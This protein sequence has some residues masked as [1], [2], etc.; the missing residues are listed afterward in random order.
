MRARLLPLSFVFAAA[1][2]AQETVP[3][4]SAMRFVP[5]D[6]I[7]VVRCAGPGAWK[8]QFAGTRLA[9]LL[10][11]PTLG[12][13]LAQ[14]G[15]ELDK[16]IAKARES[17]KVDAEA[18]ERFLGEYS[19]E[20]VVGVSCELGGLAEAIEKDE[21]PPFGVVVAFGPDGK[22]DLKTLARNA[23]EAAEDEPRLR[24]LK[25]G[26]R[27]LRVSH[28][29]DMMMTLPFELDGWQV[30]L[31][32]SEVEKQATALFAGKER[33]EMPA[34]HLQGPLAVHVTADKALDALLSA[35]AAKA[36]ENG[37]PMD[38]KAMLDQFGVASVR[39][40]D[41]VVGSDGEHA[42]AEARLSFNDKERG[43]L[44][45]L[46]PA[47]KA[48]PPTL[49]Y[50]PV[51]ADVFSITPVDLGALYRTITTV[52]DSMAEQVPMSRADA[53]AAFTE[54][55]KVRLKEDL[56]DHLGTELLVVDDDSV[57][58]V[59]GEDEDPLAAAMGAV[60]GCWA[61]H[62]KDGKAFG[63][64]LEK[65]I[66]ARGLHAGRKSEEYQGVKVSRLNL[67]GFEMEYAVTADLLLF[68]IGKAEGSKK[69]L[70][71]I[72]DE[73]AERAAGKKPGDMSEAIKTR[74]ARMPGGWQGVGAT[75]PYVMFAAMVGAMRGAIANDPRLPIAQHVKMLE[76][77]VGKLQ[78]DLKQFGLEQ[79]V[80]TQHIEASALSYR[81]R[82]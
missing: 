53:E 3:A 29:D 30:F 47:T 56:L 71:G 73:A 40:L 64:S 15:A 35:A 21:P 63:E 62:L 79:M 78:G 23:I 51:G 19:G 25:V 31:F 67:G 18:L 82:W 32:G 5:A 72:L 55:C 27:T 74:L 69:A 2:A 57:P 9:K 4:V 60:R 36:E 44:A 38:V 43:I 16:G 28:D 66:R 65:L 58:A 8:T 39:A 26:E 1:L 45:V 75:P 77:I 24:D 37:M 34:L 52:W 14:V 13:L 80:G 81:L 20:I 42:A 22:D 6:A 33:F 11:G 12:P 50:V 61:F 48:P 41:F 68:A 46:T 76:E 49:A 70:R 54:A 59:P 10:K 17:G 7:A